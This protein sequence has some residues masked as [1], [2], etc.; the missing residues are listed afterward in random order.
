MEDAGPTLY[1]C[2]TN[3]L[4]LLGRPSQKG[5]PLEAIIGE[6]TPEWSETRM[7]FASN[8]TFVFT[9]NC[10]SNS[11]LEVN[12]NYRKYPGVNSGIPN[13]YPVGGYLLP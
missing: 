9:S 5:R 4:C 2:Y 12:K 10:D 8:L 7:V 1:K 3:V 6:I 13:L 11:H